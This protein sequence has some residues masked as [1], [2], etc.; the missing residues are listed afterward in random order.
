MTS[1]WPAVSYDRWAA[2]ADTLHAHTQVLGKLAVELAPPGPE[3]RH[4]ALRLTARGWETAPL[5][6]PDGSGSLV[7]ALDLHSHRAVVEHSDGQAE[8]VPLTP[9]RPVADVANEVLAAVARL[10]GHVRINPVPQEVP[11]GVPLDEDH[12]HASYDP[13]QVA[14]YFAAATQAALALAEFGAPYRGRSTPVNAW[15]GSFDLCVTL[16]SGA[17]ADPPGDGFITRNSSD[18]EQIVVG[19]W[20]GDA[21]HPNAAF[22]AFAFPPLRVWRTP[23]CPRQPRA[24]TR[25]WASSSWTGTTYAPPRIRGRRPWSS[26]T[27]L[28]GR[29]PWRVRGAP[30]SLAAP[31]AVRRPSGE[32]PGQAVPGG[33]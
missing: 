30:T 17:P 5:P 25:T 3:L 24:G 16:F 23:R 7:V 4:G 32:Q 20:P 31:R 10:G 33:R 26:L 29:P 2:T 19:W 1:A 18:A 15:W 13:A 28:S 8:S 9:D 12:E 21:G 27:R 22:Y 14:D 6:A 11:W